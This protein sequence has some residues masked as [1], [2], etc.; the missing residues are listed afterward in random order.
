MLIQKGQKHSPNARYTPYNTRKYM[1]VDIYLPTA[2]ALA[3]S[4]SCSFPQW[5]IKTENKDNRN[6]VV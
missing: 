4:L 1:C 2:L 6:V 5:N 3:H